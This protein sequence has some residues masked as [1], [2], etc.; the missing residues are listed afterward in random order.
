MRIRAP[1]RPWY[2]SYLPGWWV[3]NPGSGGGAATVQTDGVTIQGDGSAGNKIALLDAITDGI[4]LPGAGISSSKLALKAVQNSARLTGAGT[5]ASPLDVAGWPLSYW[6]GV[7]RDHNQ[8]ISQSANTLSY[9]GFVLP[10][11]VTF[12]NLSFGVQTADAANNSDVGLYDHTGALA[13]HIGAQLLAATGYVTIAVV[14]A[15]ITIPPGIYFFAVT[16][17]AANLKLYADS[18]M[19]RY[20]AASSYGA[21][22]GGALPNSITPPAI[23]IGVGQAMHF[24]L[25]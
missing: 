4:T 1:R 12:S 3:F 11:P 9:T 22:V 8:D 25:S 17:A 14:G 19:P 18:A 20:N 10:A 21:S 15:P 5:V 16:S 13:A 2:R 6:Q 7:F 24:F 23:S